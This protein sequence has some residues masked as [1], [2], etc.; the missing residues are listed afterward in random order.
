MPVAQTSRLVLDEFSEADTPFILELL[1][2]PGWLRF[3]GD[4][5]VHDTDGANQYLENGPRKSYRDNGFGLWKVSSSATGA[6]IGM[7][8]L[9]KRPELEHPDIGFAFLPEHAGKGFA[10]EAASEVLK[11]ARDKYHLTTL[12]AIVQPDNTRS[13]ALLR[14]HNFHFVRTITVQPKQEKLELYSHQ[15]N[16]P[17]LTSTGPDSR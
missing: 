3:I 11:L 16:S 10:F 9:L 4:R 1:N 7:C 13:I 5:N 12:F 6:P 2:T 17:V 14:K 15:L 8:G